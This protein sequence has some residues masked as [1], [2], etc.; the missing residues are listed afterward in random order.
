MPGILKKPTN[1]FPVTHILCT[2]DDKRSVLTKACDA[3]KDY[4]FNTFD[5]L[6][7]P[8]FAK[9]NCSINDMRSLNNACSLPER[10]WY[11]ATFS[12]QAAAIIVIVP[13]GGLAC[14]LIGAVG[15]SSELLKELSFSTIAEENSTT[16]EEKYSDNS[17]KLLKYFEAY[18]KKLDNNWAH[19]L[20]PETERALALLT[21]LEV[22]EDHCCK[23]II[24]KEIN[25]MNIDD[26]YLPGEYVDNRHKRYNDRK[27]INKNTIIDNRDE[28]IH[29]ADLM[30][31][32][33]PHR[34]LLDSQ[35]IKKPDNYEDLEDKEIKRLILEKRE[36]ANIEYKENKG[37]FSSIEATRE[38][39]QEKILS[40]L[41]PS[42]IKFHNTHTEVQRI[43]F[44]DDNNVWVAAEEGSV[45]LPEDENLCEKAFDILS[46]DIFS[47]T[48]SGAP[49]ITSKTTYKPQRISRIECVNR[50]FSYEKL[51]DYPITVR[52]SNGITE[53]IAQQAK[54][55]SK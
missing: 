14:V 34:L 38:A 45:M 17:L 35:I 26:V 18:T 51:K 43:E 1:T 6:L 48:F 33:E 10:I 13:V 5:C 36:K 44:V 15:F 53:E 37:L 2:P 7:N 4:F 55:V 31:Y 28:C 27:I 50:P 21:H 46:R 23:N 49:E 25:K 3:S 39:Y 20:Y 16:E 47:S 12:A 52:T 19:L 54:H 11:G 29:Y 24:I 22:C 9:I 30:E 8:Y 42:K 32:L 41:K 40:S